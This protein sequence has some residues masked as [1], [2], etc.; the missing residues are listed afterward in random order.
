[1][2][3]TTRKTANQD[4]KRIEFAVQNMK[5]LRRMLR[6]IEAEDDLASQQTKQRQLKLEK[7]LRKEARQLQS[8]VSSMPELQKVKSAAAG[9]GR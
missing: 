7:D 5:V 6:L 9:S 3:W 1:M 4:I 2:A 8:I